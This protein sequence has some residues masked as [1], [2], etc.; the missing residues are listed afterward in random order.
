MPTVLTEF[1]LKAAL[2]DLCDQRNE[3]ITYNCHVELNGLS[4]DKYMEIAIFRIVQELVFNVLKHAQ[5]T[6]LSIEV[7]IE[8]NQVI[9]NVKDNGVGFPIDKIKHS[10]IGLSSIRVKTALLN[11]SLQI[12]SVPGHETSVEVKI[13]LLNNTLFKS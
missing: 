1:G 4:L 10:G 3:R 7:R 2:S 11:G 8:N 5:A 12:A 6:L 9:M 13:P